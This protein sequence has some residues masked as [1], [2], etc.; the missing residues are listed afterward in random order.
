MP[1]LPGLLSVTFRT[2]SADAVVA[3]AAD[4]GLSAVEWGGDVHV[5]HGDLAVARDVKR[6]CDARGLA[7][8]AYGS[9]LRA[10]QTGGPSVD[11]VMDTAV[12]LGAPTVR[13]WAG[14]QG[15]ADTPDR[16][17]VVDALIACC[18]A[19]ADRGLTVSTEFHGGT[20]TDTAESAADLIAAVGRPNL[21][22]F[23]QPP[24]GVATVDAMAGLAAVAPRVSNA[25]VFHWWP[26][27]QT[28]L[29]L[30]DGGDRWT[31]YLTALSALAALSGE[32]RYASLEFVRGDDPDQ[33]R[34]D[35]AT[36]KAWL[37]GLG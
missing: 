11:A 16:R 37:S 9:Y 10:G 4:A 20:L 15:S 34:R 8:S 19:A 32:T 30:A 17:P 22:T 7:V 24:E 28:R 2:L 5:P 1:L 31:L 33:F 12:A 3:L 36:L 23:W 18:D 29:P 21:R 13:V 35:A 6:K 27:G 25:H 14:T 26:T